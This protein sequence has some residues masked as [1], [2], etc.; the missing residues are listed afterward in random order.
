MSYQG[1]DNPKDLIIDPLLASTY[2][3]GSGGE[4]GSSVAIDAGGNVYV[5]GFTYSANFPTTPGA[6]RTFNKGGYD[7]SVFRLDSNL[8]GNNAPVANAGTDQSVHVGNTVT[9]DGSGSTDID[10]NLLTYSW[11]FTSKPSG[12]T[13]TLVNPTSV[14]P[15]FMVDKA[16]TYVMSLI[17][18][19][20]TVDSTPD[21]VTVSTL[22]SAPVANAGTDQ[23]VYVGNTVTLD[24]SGSTDIDGNLLTY[25]WA[26]TTKPDGSTATL[27][28]TT[29]V[30]PTFTVDKAGTYVV[31]LTVNDGTVNGNPD[32]V[33]VSTLNSAPVANAGAGADTS[34]YVGN[35]VT[36]DGRGSSDVD[37][38]LLTY[39]WAFTSKP[40]GSTATLSN[41]T[42]VNPTFTMDKAGTYVVSLTVND[43]TVNGTPDTVTISTLNS[44][45]V[46]NAGAN[47]SVYIGNTMTH[48]G[49]G[50]SDADGNTLTYSWAFTS[51]PSGI[52]ATLSNA[53][54]V[55]PTFTVDKAGTY[56]VSLIV[57]DGT[58]NSS[59]DTVNI[60]TINVAP[61]ANAGNDQT[62]PE[63]STVTL[64]GSGS[65]DADG[66]AL[67]YSWAF[68]TKPADSTATLINATA[69]NP[70][71]TADEEGT[72]VVS[73]IV[74]DGTVNSSPDTVTINATNVTPK[75]IEA[76][77]EIKPETINLKSKGKF[78][79][80]IEL[81][82]PYNAGDIVVETVVRSGAQAI[83]GRTDGRDRF[84]ATFNPTF[85]IRGEKRLF[86]G[87][88]RPE[89]LDF[90]GVNFQK[91][92]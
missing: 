2:L 17:V 79:A 61:V 10:G 13:A 46:A 3:G 23:S 42:A 65:S 66:N 29:T 85:A 67:T 37:G 75:V 84:V 12:S 33:T 55:N 82:S 50:S 49:S 20:G 11:A 72:Y 39:S 78:K 64:D 21:T 15:T 91:G 80:F 62:V 57:N 28:G 71:F 77:V 35:T 6:Y 31:S 9:L 56:V 92:L 73:L 8:S 16:G 88:K 68:T 43:G 1:R 38:N 59:P 22:N 24:G 87:M 26:F 36:L 47:Q 69:V 40:S 18:N 5:T 25:N 81:P 76:E 14:N 89:T 7:V 41:A 83:D 4:G 60:S 90:K 34:V 86:L 53:T 32:T 63:E 48:D 58:V 27:S 70:T 19:D 45:P 44:T 74:N 51:K 52:T 54:A 30:N